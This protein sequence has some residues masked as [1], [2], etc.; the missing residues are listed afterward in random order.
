MSEEDI[1]VPPIVHGPV[2]ISYGDLNGFEFGTKVRNPYQRLFERKPDDVI[3]NGV[4]VFYGDF[5][6]PEAAALEYVQQ[7]HV[8]LTKDPQAALSAAQSAVA[9]VPDGFDAN[10]SLGDAFEATGNYA[11]AGAAYAV[12]MRRIQDMEPSAQEYWRPILEAKVAK[13]ASDERR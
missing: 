4:A 7:A 1:Y 12:A 10:V 6:L 3:A 11:A 9:L 5:T 13:V 2:L 8:N